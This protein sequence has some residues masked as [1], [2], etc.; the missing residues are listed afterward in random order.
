VKWKAYPEYKDSGMQWP[1]KTPKN[2][3]VTR[4]KR[5]AYFVYGESLSTEDRISGMYQ[6]FG[7]NGPVGDHEKANTN[8]P[9]LVIGRKGSFGKV[10]YSANPC[11]A[12]DTTYF[13]DKTS[14]NNDLRWLYYCLQWL[15]LDA[16]SKDTGVPGLARED[17]YENL[18]PFCDRE[19]QHA[20][21][22]FLDRE[23]QRIDSLI[24]KKQRQIELLQ[25]KRS[26]LISHV[27]TKSLD[28]NVKMKDS[29]V[30][31]QGEIPEHWDKA[32]IIRYAKLRTG[33]T[34]DRDNPIYWENGTVNWMSSGEVNKVYVYDTDQKITFEGMNHSNASM[35]PEN[36][37]MIALNGQG[38]TK[39][40]TAILKISSSCNQS[41]AGFICDEINLH[42]NYLFYFL[43]S[44]YK[45]LRGL[46]GDGL[47]DGLSLSLLKEIYVFVPPL[48]EQK[49]IANYLDSE[50]VTFD[51]LKNIIELSIIKL[52]E[53]RSALISAAV[54]GKID[55]RQEVF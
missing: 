48:K 29:G 54:T 53:Y 38:K 5:I 49:T 12:I 11:F 21:A 50:I 43:T 32:K 20:I 1:K 36:S 37:V 31:W 6:V 34:P 51:K 45:D 30:E 55:V 42:Y 2:W 15:K 17:A 25:E 3:E 40:M 52:K 9:C 14:T 19:E 46:V 44:R 27:V 16:F 13:V 24:A 35:L 10:T 4:L 41:L 33:G 7:S 28:P 8:G 39:G 23:T 22:A 18:I 26:T 47:R